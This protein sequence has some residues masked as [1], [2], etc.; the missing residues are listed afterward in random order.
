MQIKLVY[1][2][3]AVHNFVNQFERLEDTEGDSELADDV[4]VPPARQPMNG[5]V[6]DGMLKKRDQIAKD[7][8]ESYERYLTQN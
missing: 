2:L 1:A 7:M 5:Q 4:N 3:A 6:L 8:W